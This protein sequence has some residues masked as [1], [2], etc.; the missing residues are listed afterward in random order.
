MNFIMP[1]LPRRQTMKALKIHN[2]DEGLVTNNSFEVFHGSMAGETG[3]RGREGPSPGSTN[4]IS[5]WDPGDQKYNENGPFLLLLNCFSA[6]SIVALVVLRHL[7]TLRHLV[8]RP[9]R[10]LVAPPPPHTPLKSFVQPWRTHIQ[11]QINY[12]NHFI[13]L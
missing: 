5:W 11:L 13:I 2:L 6:I 9:L 10:H 8:L 12:L 1:E 3:G 7:D 4:S